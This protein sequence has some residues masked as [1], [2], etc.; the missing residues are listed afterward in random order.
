MMPQRLSYRRSLTLP[1][2][3]RTEMLCLKGR[4]QCQE[5]GS[6]GAAEERG[7]HS[8]AHSQAGR[9]GPH[10]EGAQRRSDQ[11]RGVEQVR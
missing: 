7:E 1:L 10:C 11:A 4:G 5:P 6:A 2:L 8:R 9:T 3:R